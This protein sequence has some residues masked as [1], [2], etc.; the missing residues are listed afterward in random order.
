MTSTLRRHR[1]SVVL[2]LLLLAMMVSWWTTTEAPVAASAQ[3]ELRMPTSKILVVYYSRTGTT[4]KLAGAIATPLGADL[5]PLQDTVDRAGAFGFLRSLVDAMRRRG[6][7]LQPLTV[8]P[9]AYELVLVGTPVWGS[10]A[11]APVRTFFDHYRGKLPEVAF[12]LT[13]GTTSHDAVW[14]DMTKLAGRKPVATLGIAQKDVLA[15]R[16]RD[17][18]TAFIDALPRAPLPERVPSM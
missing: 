2:A 18:V 11:A 9:A 15:D 17:K 16:Y 14:A 7:T 3:K 10:A 4:A 6:T 13:D 1:L 5:E 8:D 12:F